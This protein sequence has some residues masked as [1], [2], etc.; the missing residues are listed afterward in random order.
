MRALGSAVYLLCAATSVFCTVLLFRTYR[1]ERRPLLFWSTLCFVGLAINNILL[2]LDLVVLPSI[3]LSLLR[4]LTS[5]GAVA[6]LLYG[7]IWEAD[8]I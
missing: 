7:F 5:F 6:V 4:A 1:I 8:R 2:F 3:D